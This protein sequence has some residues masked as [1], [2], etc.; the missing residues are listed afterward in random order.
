LFAGGGLL[1][2]EAAVDIDEVLR[3]ERLLPHEYLQTELLNLRVNLPNTL[4]ILALFSSPV[5][6]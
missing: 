4:I 3:R 1:T 2:P 6:V 5:L